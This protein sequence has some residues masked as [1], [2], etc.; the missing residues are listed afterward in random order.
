MLSKTKWTFSLTSLVVLI[1][2]G[3]AYV[4]SPVMAHD[5]VKESKLTDPEKEGLPEWK[6]W[7]SVDE[8]VQDVSSDDGVQIASSRTRA[9]RSIAN[10]PD[11]CSCGRRGS[12]HSFSHI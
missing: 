9:F 12:N 8:S 2:F 3:L 4:A 1:A 6:V 10:V 11:S 7:L 5:V